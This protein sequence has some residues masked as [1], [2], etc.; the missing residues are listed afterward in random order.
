MDGPIASDRVDKRENEKPDKME[1]LRL[2]AKG[3]LWN[4]FLPAV[5]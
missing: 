3:Q 5:L 2:S 4:E 1:N